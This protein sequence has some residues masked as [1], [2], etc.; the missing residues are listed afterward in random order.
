MN[1]FVT[2][3]TRALHRSKQHS[4]TGCAGIDDFVAFAAGDVAMLAGQ[5]K[6]RNVVIE[7]RILPRRRLVTGFTPPGLNLSGELSFM[8]I[9]VTALT[10]NI[11]KVEQRTLS[12]RTDVHMTMTGHTR[13][14]QMSTR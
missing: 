14:G 10:G 11:G 4:F 13:Y 3:F 1:V 9:F 7:F 8:N 5:G 2:V 12:C 6:A